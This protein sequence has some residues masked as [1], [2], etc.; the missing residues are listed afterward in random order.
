MTLAE[1]EWMMVAPALAADLVVELVN[2][3][4]WMDEAACSRTGSTPT[5][6]PERGGR[7]SAA[8]MVCARC[9]VRE[10]CLRFAMRDGTL[11]GVWGGT[12]ENRRRVMRKPA[13]PK[14]IQHGT[15]GGYGVEQKRGLP[16]C[17][18][19]RRAHSEA[20][21]RRRALRSV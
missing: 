15:A 7:L 11:S 12:S 10:E 21:Q 14:P 9:P 1:S 8:L 13:G 18:E 20:N 4:S 3:P 2:R 6:F 19:C 5:F 16:H 17:A